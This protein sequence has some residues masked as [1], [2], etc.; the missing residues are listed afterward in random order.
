MLTA[1]LA[2]QAPTQTTPGAGNAT[3]IQTAKNSPFVSSAYNFILNQVDQLQ[4]DNL[5]VQTYDAIANPDTCIQHR[6]NLTLAK[7]QAIVAQLLEEGLLNPAD[8]KTFPGGLLAGVFPPVLNDG[9]A[10][11]HLPQRFWSAPGSSFGGH[12]SYPGGLPVHESNNDTA[13]I[14]L[15]EEYRHVYGQ[16]KDGLAHVD[17]AGIVNPAP[18]TG[19]PSVARRSG[20][21]GPRA[22]CSSGMPT[23][24]NFRS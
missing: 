14:N 2:A 16:S 17:R 20:M 11:P 9:T 6:A 7:K 12:H 22:S 8:D 23:V 15:A 5:R 10:C 1:T 13:D 4:G 3:A 19:S 21:T 18:E 24:Q